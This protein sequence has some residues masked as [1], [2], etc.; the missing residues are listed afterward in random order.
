M[1]RGARAGFAAGINIPAMVPGD[2]LAHGQADTGAGIFVFPV[3]PFENAE[4]LLRVFLVEADA[5]ITDPDMVID[6][7]GFR[8]DGNKSWY[9]SPGEFQGIRH[10]VDK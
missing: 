4:D 10:Q 2:L 9:I 8:C 7:F 5:I 3:Q 6:V 1:E